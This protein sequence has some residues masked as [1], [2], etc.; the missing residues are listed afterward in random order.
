M[1]TGKKLAKV[2]RIAGLLIIGGFLVEVLTLIWSH[3]AS[4]LLYMGVGG[5][6]MV[7]GIVL[8]LYAVISHA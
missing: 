6:L 5:V 7:I 1:K 3:P 8:Y 4:F 2:L